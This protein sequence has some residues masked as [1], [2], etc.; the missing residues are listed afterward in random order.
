MCFLLFSLGEAQL[1]GV[2]GSLTSQTMFDSGLAPLDD[3]NSSAESHSLDPDSEG[4]LKSSFIALHWC[5]L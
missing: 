3:L 5:F 4:V 2:D 1:P